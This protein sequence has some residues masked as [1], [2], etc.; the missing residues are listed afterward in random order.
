MSRLKQANKKRVKKKSGDCKVSGEEKL[1]KL[2][3]QG[4]QFL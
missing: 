4:D 3:N 2:W 1:R